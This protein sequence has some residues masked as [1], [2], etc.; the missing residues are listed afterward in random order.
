MAPAEGHIWKRASP[1]NG[2]SAFANC[3]RAVR[4]MPISGVI[5]L[6]A[7]SALGLHLKL[8]PT[9][10][11][12]VGLRPMARQAAARGRLRAGAAGRVGCGLPLTSRP[13]RPAHAPVARG[14]QGSCRGGDLAT[15]IGGWVS[16]DGLCR[17]GRRV[18]ARS[19]R[20]FCVAL[21]G[22][23]TVE[24]EQRPGRQ[25]HRPLPDPQKRSS[26]TLLNSPC[27][28]VV[29]QAVLAAATH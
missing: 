16:A 27:R 1:W 29:R 21:H 10:S 20:S 26:A 23:R 9:R 7:R 3:G 14:A 18:R 17:K 19:S 28:S 8:Q 22:L 25:H 2:V 15:G 6:R 5:E 24:G 11:D 13:G 12:L 4:F